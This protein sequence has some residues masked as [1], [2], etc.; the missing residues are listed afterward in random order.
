MGK[1]G[2]STRARKRHLA[3]ARPLGPG[4]GKHPFPSLVLPP[5]PQQG[6]TDLKQLVRERAE[7]TALIEA[8]VDLLAAEGYSWPDIAAALGVTRQAARQAHAR[9]HAAALASATSTRARRA[10][11]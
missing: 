6:L 3:Q 5:G 8:Q 4:G 2:K 9:R 7:I 10:G 1:R 11:A